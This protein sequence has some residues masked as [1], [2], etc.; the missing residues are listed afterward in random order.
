MSHIHHVRMN[1]EHVNSGAQ[2][3]A[4]GAFV[5]VELVDVCGVKIEQHLT[6]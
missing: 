5:R 2:N 3:N 1:Y 6:Q 4:D